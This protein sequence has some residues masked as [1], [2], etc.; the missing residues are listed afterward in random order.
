MSS[1]RESRA[2]SLAP[3]VSVALLVWAVVVVAVSGARTAAPHIR[4]L[5]RP[6]RMRAMFATPFAGPDTQRVGSGVGPLMHRQYSVDIP[7]SGDNTQVNSTALMR[8]IKQQIAQLSPSALAEF[9]KTNGDP[10]EMVVGDEYHI[11]MLGP[12]NGR[13]RVVA[14]SPESFT[15]ATLTGHPESGHITF[16]VRELRTRGRPLRVSI[17]S[18]ARSRDATVDMMYARLGVGMHVQARV[19]VTFLRRACT[20]AGLNVPPRIRIQ[21]E[22]VGA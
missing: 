11:A 10:G 2:A 13:V 19:W 7:R 16:L 8:A 18:W 21:S 12:W 17:E 22:E 15:L 1:G 9:H 6:G 14:V 20:L 3:F 5:T 4:R